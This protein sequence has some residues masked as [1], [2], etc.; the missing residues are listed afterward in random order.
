MS[1]RYILRR[2][3]S[4][5]VAT[6]VTS[7]LLSSSIYAKGDKKVQGYIVSSSEL[8]RVTVLNSSREIVRVIDAPN[9]YDSWYLESGNILFTYHKGV[10]IITPSDSTLFHY[11]SDSEIFA[12]QPL[13]KDR[14]LIGECSNGRLIEVDYSGNILKEIALTY[15]NGGHNCMRSARKVKG[16]NYLVCHYGDR[17]VREYNSRGE[18]VME[19]VRPDV[20]VA[21]KRIRGGKTVISDRTTLSIY[22]R[23]GELIWE[24]NGSDYPELGVN[25]LSGFHAVSD[26]EFIV[27][28]WLGHK[29]FKEGVPIFK[30]NIEKSILWKYLNAEETYSC[31]S[32]RSF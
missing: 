21:A 13:A 30:I 4:I 31:G 11:E 12:C 17:T 16:G 22:S 9:S 19:F 27:C 20:V 5:V 15:K 32:V 18:V 6:V 29:P 10:K 24:F 25:H 2:V 3:L 14:I 1:M 8:N 28:N 23:R 26:S 7:T